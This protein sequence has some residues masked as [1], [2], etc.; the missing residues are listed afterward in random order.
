MKKTAIFL[1]FLLCA[2]PLAAQRFYQP[3]EVPAA[4][5]S[6]DFPL[7]VRIL[8]AHWSYVHMSYSGYGRGNILLE[9][10]TVGFDYTYSCNEPFLANAQRGEFYQARWKKQDQKIEILTQEVGNTK[11][12]HKCEL[13]VALKD[14]PY[15]GNSSAQK[16]PQKDN[17]GPQ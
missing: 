17:H 3:P 16:A 9:G 15:G 13:K 12:V 6:S 1:L 8:Q 14:A 4:E 11:H 2:M 5:I 10:G 7:R